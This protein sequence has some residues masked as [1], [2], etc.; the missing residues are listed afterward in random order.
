ILEESLNKLNTWEQHVQNG[1]ISEKKFLTRQTADGLRVT[2][3][4]TLDIVNYLTLDA[5]F[6]SVLT[7]R[8]NQDSLEVF[9]NPLKPNEQIRFFGSIRQAAGSNDHPGITTFLQSYKILSTL[10]MLKPPRYGNCSVIED[11]KP[12]ISISDIKQLYQKSNKKSLMKLKKKLNHA[13]DNN[14]WTF[15][16]YMT[17]HDYYRPEVTDCIVYYIIQRDIYITIYLNT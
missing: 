3:K 17:E 14:E 4:S 11:S 9:L 2:I 13:I 7:G 12:L 15:Q 6:D 8:L 5:G 10:S 16:D 1:D